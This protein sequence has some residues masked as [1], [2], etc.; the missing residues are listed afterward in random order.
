MPDFRKIALSVQDLAQGERPPEFSVFSS[1]EEFMQAYGLKEYA[2]R[3]DFS[4][5]F[6]VIVH[7]GPCPTGGYRITIEKVEL[8]KPGQLAVRVRLE[9]PEPDDIVTLIGTNPRDM[10]LVPKSLTANRDGSAVFSFIDQRGNCLA[11]MSV[12]TH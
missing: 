11:R 9:E 7:Q 10:V 8:G 6:L 2:P 5:Y 1:E 3:V 12:A 4:R